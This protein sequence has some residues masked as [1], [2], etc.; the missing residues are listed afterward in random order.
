MAFYRRPSPLELTYIAQDSTH[1]SP[2][3]NQYVIEGDG[4]LSLTEMTHAVH[5]AARQFPEARL[6]LLGRGPWRAWHDDGA[7]PRVAEVDA[8]D[9]DGLSGEAA[10]CLGAPL[11]VRTGPVCEV[12]LLRGASLRVLFRTHHGVTDGAGTLF[13][14][15]QVFAALRGAPLTAPASC[16]TEWD[17]ATR[18][19]PV[20][21][22]VALGGC[23]PVYRH[24]SVPWEPGCRWQ[25][26]T[27]DGVPAGL[28]GKV[29][30][31]V[32]GWARQTGAQRLIF[33]MPADL[34]RYL[35]DDAF[36]SANCS[37]AL[38][39][40]VPVDASPKRMQ[41]AIVTAMRQRQD[42]ATL[43][44]ALRWLRWLPLSMLRP[45]PVVTQ[46]THAGG[47][48]GYSCTITNLG[49]LAPDDI[50]GAG[51]R[52]TLLFGVPIPLELT[53]LYIAFIQVGKR[54][55]MHVAIPKALGTAD[56]LAS[57]CE[58]LREALAGNSGTSE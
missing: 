2:V 34:R 6:R 32:A 50:S 3:V 22:T 47:R 41:Q 30:A 42:L 27:I 45:N 43:V 54:T 25:R 17:V 57:L 52:G 40:E 53:P 12:I 14:I 4:D 10:P 31:V 21:K 9:W 58:A 15:R 28:G 7:L 19:P 1:G 48:Y 33:R 13:F 49:R 11:N 36:T 39:L 23:T 51:F 29:M 46:K 24:G 55:A 37:S 38:D 16:L 44:P 20:A 18:E 26:F 35:P 56:D 5:A 8:R